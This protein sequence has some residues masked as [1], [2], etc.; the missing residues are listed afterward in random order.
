MSLLVTE[1][2]RPE[3][4]LGTQFQF[5]SVG[6]WI[7]ILA[8]LTIGTS[9]DRTMSRWQANMSS[10]LISEEDIYLYSGMHDAAENFVC[11][12]CWLFSGGTG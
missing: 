8:I 12:R 2:R 10:A 11:D 9:G 5:L 6:T 4:G 3:C 7:Q 1:V